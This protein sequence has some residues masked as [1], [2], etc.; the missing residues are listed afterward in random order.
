MLAEEVD[1][2]HLLMPIVMTAVE[3]DTRGWA[4]TLRLQEALRAEP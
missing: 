3:R 4:L 2:E 1:V